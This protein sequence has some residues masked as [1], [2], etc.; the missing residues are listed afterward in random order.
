MV[1]LLAVQYLSLGCSQVRKL[2]H[3][4]KEYQCQTNLVCLQKRPPHETMVLACQQKI[5]QAGIGCLGL[6][7]FTRITCETGVCLDGCDLHTSYCR[8]FI[9]VVPSLSFSFFCE[10]VM[11]HLSVFKRMMSPHQHNSYSKSY[12]CE[13]SLKGR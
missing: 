8:S 7:E 4:S 6:W 12:S 2:C 10:G 13:R 1:P 5:L 9:P 11:P 3:Q